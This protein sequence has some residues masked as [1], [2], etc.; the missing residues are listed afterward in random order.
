[1]RLRVPEALRALEEREFRLFFVGQSVSLLGDGMVGVALA[2]AVLDL[3]GSASDLG[4]V[5]AART[6][7]LVGFLLAGGVFADRLSRRAVMVGS[8]VVRL[9]SPGGT[10]AFLVRLTLPPHVRL[11]PQRFLHDLR[12]GWKEFRSRTW[13]WVGVWAAG[14]ANMMSAAFFVL[15]AVIAK[16]SLGGAGSWALILA[17][18][19][20]GA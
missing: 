12:D 15:G 20:V 6:I 4:Y 16:T 11:P 13:L 7:P 14:I 5:F 18:F 8:D 19:G 9:G 3:T 17:A 10:A 1:M 2:F